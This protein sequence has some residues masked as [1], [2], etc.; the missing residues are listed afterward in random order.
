[1][2]TSQ[3]VGMW[4]VAN[5]IK[6]RASDHARY[7]MYMD[8]IHQLHVTHKDHI[9]LAYIMQNDHSHLPCIM[10][11]DN[12][13]LTCIMNNNRHLL[14]IMQNNIIHL[15]YCDTLGANVFTH[16]TFCTKIIFICHALCMKIMYTCH[17][18]CKKMIHLLYRTHVEYSDDTPFVHNA[19]GI[20][21]HTTSPPSNGTRVLQGN[22][23]SNCWQRQTELCWVWRSSN[24][25][26][27]TLN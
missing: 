1:M 23:A 10:Y 19:C 7:N 26:Q 17:T 4:S 25:V 13:H 24:T 6:P 2:P 15:L 8:H 9:H 20:Q 5:S 3:S 16:Y 14:Y 11:K 18:L 21:P 12:N 22:C 27:R